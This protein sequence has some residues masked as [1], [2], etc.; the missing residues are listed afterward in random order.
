M[1]SLTKSMKPKQTDTGNQKSTRN[2][3]IIQSPPFGAGILAITLFFLIAFLS[4]I[5]LAPVTVATLGI[6]VTVSTFAILALIILILFI[7]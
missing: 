7:F 2:I 1:D 6:T 5:I 4:N 3:Q